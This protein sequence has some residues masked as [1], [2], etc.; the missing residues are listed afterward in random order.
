M[1]NNTKLGVLLSLTATLLIAG[2]S[3]TATTS[4]GESVGPIFMTDYIDLKL[5]LCQVPVS[6]DQATE[7]A[8]VNAT[9]SPAE[10]Q[11]EKKEAWESWMTVIQEHKTDVTAKPQIFNV[12]TVAVFERDSDQDGVVYFQDD[13]STS[14]SSQR[15]K[16]KWI[17]YHSSESTMPSQILT[18]LRGEGYHFPIP[19]G[20][21]DWQVHPNME[22]R[23]EA[24]INQ[25]KS[26]AI[27]DYYQSYFSTSAEQVH[28]VTHNFNAR[29]KV[30]SDKTSIGS[31]RYGH[32]VLI[33]VGEWFEHPD[34]LI[35]KTENGEFVFDFRNI[36]FVEKFGFYPDAKDLFVRVSYIYQIS[37]CEGRNLMGDIKEV[38]V[39]TPNNTEIFRISI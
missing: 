26:S 24:I 30:T 16:F 11:A 21:V 29:T 34:S 27:E 9:M 23:R 35:K 17:D 4:T 7:Y 2:C 15:Q 18:I 10:R 31:D 19:Y 32:G 13:R 38:V 37:R 20:L 22:F 1:Q 36:D 39:Y 12:D 33:N 3:S 28:V 8:G 14:N 6:Y 5:G 25:R